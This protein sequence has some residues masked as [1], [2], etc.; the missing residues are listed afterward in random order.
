MV[1]GVMW[2]HA[3]R[4]VLCVDNQSVGKN[5]PLWELRVGWYI[6]CW[7]IRKHHGI[8]TL[9]LVFCFVEFIE[10]YCVNRVHQYAKCHGQCPN[11]FAIVSIDKHHNER[12][13]CQT[14]AE[15]ERE[16][17]LKPKD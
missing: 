4:A 8:S 17:I 14:Y 6:R 3:S 1:V 2:W 13:Y 7:D 16:Q 10:L 9:S 15:N 11:G 5:Y 12:Q